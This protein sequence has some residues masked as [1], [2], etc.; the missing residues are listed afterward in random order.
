MD[1]DTRSRDWKLSGVALPAILQRLFPQNDHAAAAINTPKASQPSQDLDNMIQ[2]TMNALQL[3]H[4]QIMAGEECYVEEASTHNIFKGWDSGF[5][6]APSASALNSQPSS[7]TRLTSDHRWFSNSCSNVEALYQQHQPLDR[8]VP[9]V[10]PNIRTRTTGA[11]PND[12]MTGNQ[13]LKNEKISRSESFYKEEA[14]NDDDKIEEDPVLNKKRI[15]ATPL[16][17]QRRTK[18]TRRK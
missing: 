4:H 6:D 12:E 10:R 16:A 11:V 9:T 13:A 1:I 8:Y 18:R 14:H 2:E 3:V 15:T 7:S 5:I 17:Q